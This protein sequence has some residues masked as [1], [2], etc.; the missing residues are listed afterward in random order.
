[1][2]WLCAGLQANPVFDTSSTKSTDE[3]AD[4]RG[5]SRVLDEGS[6]VYSSAFVRRLRAC[7]DTK[8]YAAFTL[9][10]RGM[11]PSAVDQELRSMQVSVAPEEPR[12]CGIF[13]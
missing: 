3:T 12:G 4:A 1:M 9:Y 10:L 13:L 5:R 6:D 2:S 11:T 7:S 8:D